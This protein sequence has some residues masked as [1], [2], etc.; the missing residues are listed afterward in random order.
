MTWAD[1]HSESERLAIEAQLELRSHNALRAMELY[2]RAA[3]FEQV[4]SMFL[5]SGL[6][7]RCLQISV[8]QI[9]PVKI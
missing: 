6:P 9:L 1:L 2:K 7:I 3:Q 5:Q 4:A 8:F